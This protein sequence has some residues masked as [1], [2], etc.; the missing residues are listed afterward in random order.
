VAFK[1]KIDQHLNGSV[2]NSGKLNEDT[3]PDKN[4]GSFITKMGFDKKTGEKILLM[5]VEQAGSILSEI[6]SYIKMD[7]IKDA[8]FYLHK[9]KGSAGNIGAMTIFKEAKTA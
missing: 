4:P 2:K 6:K 9:L 3:K 5:F 1:D 8:S 7:Q